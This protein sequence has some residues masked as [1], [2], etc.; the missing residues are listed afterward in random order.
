MMLFVDFISLMPADYVFHNV[1]SNQQRPLCCSSH[2]LRLHSGCIWH[3]SQ[4]F[5]GD[6]CPNTNRE[7]AGKGLIWVRLALILF[8]KKY[9]CV[10]LTYVIDC[11]RHVDCNSDINF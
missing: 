1:C 9:I 2:Y 8:R 4:V 7:S 11:T 10:S 6:R 5:H 3:H